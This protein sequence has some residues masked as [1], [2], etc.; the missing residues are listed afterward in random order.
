MS[1]DRQQKG[2][3]ILVYRLWKDALS[4]VE[5]GLDAVYATRFA[6]LEAIVSKLP[7]KRTQKPKSLCWTI[8][9]LSLQ[10]T[11]W[12]LPHRRKCKGFQ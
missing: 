8:G 5:K 6:S 10:S 1:F 9:R 11:P 7:I 4:K 12:M 3:C 2:L